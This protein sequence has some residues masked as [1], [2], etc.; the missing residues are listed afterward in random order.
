MKQ[1]IIQLPA[2]E[3]EDMKEY[4]ERMRETIEIL[5][6]KETVRK[7]SKALKRVDSG[8]FLTKKDMVFDV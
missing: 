1:S 5:S 6:S 3:Y 4:M 7:I 8:E 2:E